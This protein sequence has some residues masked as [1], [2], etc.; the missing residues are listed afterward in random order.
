MAV[1]TCE[2]RYSDLFEW[3]L[4]NA[5]GV[6]MGLYG[7]DYLYNNP[8]LCRGGITRRLWFLIPCCPSKLPRTW[9]SL[10]NYTYSFNENV[11]WIH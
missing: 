10:G 9:A 2:A 6:G 8:L 3:Q 11:L 4:Y 5:A 1:I 7:D